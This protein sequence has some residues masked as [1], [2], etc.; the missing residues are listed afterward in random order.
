VRPFKALLTDLSTTFFTPKLYSEI[1]GRRAL[2]YPLVHRSPR[3][4]TPDLISSLASTDSIRQKT[5]KKDARVRR[6][7][8]RRAVS[9]GYL[10]ALVRDLDTMISD[11]GASLVLGE[12]MLF[13][14]GDKTQAINA[15]LSTLS[16][17]PSIIS[18]SRLYKTLLQG[19]HFS[20]STKSIARSPAFAP[21]AFA[22]AFLAQV[23]EGTIREMAKG[24][25]AFVVAEL[26][27]RVREGGSEKDHARLATVF[28]KAGKNIRIEV[29]SS[30]PRGW[31]VLVGKLEQIA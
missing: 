27:E 6:D 21:E 25:G 31:E 3:H 15:L 13:A 23:P 16:A 14:E 20:H 29:E 5:S 1:T 8:V 11:A 10:A 7:E 28:G 4:F 24:D 22:S 17:N 2:L 26:I 12:V 19:G 9:D 18:T 30:Q